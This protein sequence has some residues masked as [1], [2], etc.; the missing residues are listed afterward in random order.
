MSASLQWLPKELHVL[1]TLCRLVYYCGVC[2]SFYRF[3]V[4]WKK[5]PYGQ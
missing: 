4:M 1:A 5:K 3:Y 2:G